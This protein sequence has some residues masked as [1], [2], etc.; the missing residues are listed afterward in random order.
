M[1]KVFYKNNK[2]TFQIRKDTEY[3][4][5][6]VINTDSITS[7]ETVEVENH[8]FVEMSCEKKGLYSCLAFYNDEL[9][10]VLDYL[11][12]SVVDCGGLYDAVLED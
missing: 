10:D 7:V 8:K 1:F 9:V 6:V 2:P 3:S 12:D 11:N 5:P 4:I